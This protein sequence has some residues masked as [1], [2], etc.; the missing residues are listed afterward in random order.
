MKS[1]ARLTLQMASPA[2]GCLIIELH[3]CCHPLLLWGRRL[4]WDGRSTCDSTCESLETHGL[5]C[6]VTHVIT[7]LIGRWPHACL[8]GEGRRACRIGVLACDSTS[9]VLPSLTLIVVR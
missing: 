7:R 1:P 3:L 8:P 5:S 4:C 2:E 9:G 6:V